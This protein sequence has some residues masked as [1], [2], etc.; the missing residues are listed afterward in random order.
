MSEGL[1]MYNGSEFLEKDFSSEILEKDGTWAMGSKDDY[2]KTK[3]DKCGM[4][5]LNGMRV[6][7]LDTECGKRRDVIWKHDKKYITA[8]DKN[9]REV[10]WIGRDRCRTKDQQIDWINQIAGKTW[11]DR[12]CFTSALKKACTDWGLW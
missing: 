12:Y 6:I 1:E 8:H 11:G 2:D 9:K 10:Y 4:H 7:H 5:S 3:C